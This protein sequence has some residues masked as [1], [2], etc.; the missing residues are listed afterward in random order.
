MANRNLKYLSDKV[1]E[2]SNEFNFQESARNEWIVV[3]SN[4][5]R[6]RTKGQN[7]HYLVNFINGK[8]IEVNSDYLRLFIPKFRIS[9][10]I[11]NFKQLCYDLRSIT[12]PALSIY[13]FL[14]ETITRKEFNFLI[15]MARKEY[16]CLTD[17]QEVYV[18]QINLKIISA[19]DEVDLKRVDWEWYGIP[20][21]I[22]NS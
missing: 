5:V 15:D 12:H 10:V 19:V 20:L 1:V 7:T 4:E 2:M 14:E 22:I 16:P 11:P 8:K 21:D 6:A 3:K 18:R 13:S 9:T 17:K